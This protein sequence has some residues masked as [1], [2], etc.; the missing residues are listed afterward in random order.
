MCSPDRSILF[1]LSIGVITSA[2]RYRP[3]LLRGI[4]SLMAWVVRTSASQQRAAR[5]S[6]PRARA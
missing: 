5:V 6:A 3:D 1:G 2:A 4:T